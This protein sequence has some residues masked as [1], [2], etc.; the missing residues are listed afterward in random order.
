[1]S[2]ILLQIQNGAFVYIK[3]II[4][5]QNNKLKLR[6]KYQRVSAILPEIQ[7]SGGDKLS[8]GFVYIRQP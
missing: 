8:G 4:N 2:A 3:P 7:N 6:L 5:I 1:L